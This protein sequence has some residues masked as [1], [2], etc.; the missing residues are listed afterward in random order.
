[1]DIYAIE[2]ILEVEPVRPLSQFVLRRKGRLASRGWLLWPRQF[3]ETSVV[4]SQ[5]GAELYPWWVL[6]TSTPTVVVG[7][8]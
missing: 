1:M 3:Y 4:P 7:V 6:P 5:R 8:L 2:K